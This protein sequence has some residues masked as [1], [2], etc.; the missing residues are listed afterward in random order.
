MSAVF[1]TYGAINV[2]KEYAYT[3][4]N[5][6]A[7]ATAFR[8]VRGVRILD[9]EGNKTPLRGLRVKVDVSGL[10]APTTPV[11]NALTVFKEGEIAKLDANGTYTFY[12]EGVVEYGVYEL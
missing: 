7:E 5:V 6:P 1:T 10:T 8:I 9:S 3:A 12:D 4:D 11:P 2:T